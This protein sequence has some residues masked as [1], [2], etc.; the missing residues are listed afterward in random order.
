MSEKQKLALV[1][2]TLAIALVLFFIFLAV[3]DFLN[4]TEANVES[5]VAYHMELIVHAREERVGAAVSSLRSD[6]LLG[7]SSLAC[8]GTSDAAEAERFLTLF[9]S[10]SAFDEL[11]VAYPDGSSAYGGTAAAGE[12]W[13]SDAA[14]GNSGIFAG[15]DGTLTAYAPV[16][17]NGR[18]ALL[19]FGR[20]GAAHLGAGV[21]ERLGEQ[22]V[23]FFLV[24]KSGSFLY[25]PAEQGLFEASDIEAAGGFFAALA[26]AKYP[27]GASAEDIQSGIAQNASGSFRMKTALQDAY[28]YY[29]PAGIADWHVVL[30][31]DYTALSAQHA[32]LGRMAMELLLK[33]LFALLVAALLMLFYSWASKQEALNSANR[34]N[35]MTNAIPGGVQQFEAFGNMEFRYVSDGFFQMTGYS[36]A[37]IK[38]TFSN[39]FLALIHPEDRAQ[40]ESLLRANLDTQTPLELKYRILAKDGRVVWLLNRATLCADAESAAYYQCVCVDITHLKQVEQTLASKAQLDQLT[41]LYNRETA[42]MFIREFLNETAGRNFSHAFFMLDM[43]GFK[44]H[45]DTYGHV[46]GDRLLCRVASI[47]G[48]IFRGTDI[49]CRLAGDEF[50][51]FMKNAE[52]RE[53]IAEKAQGVL[54]GVEELRLGGAA[55]PVSLSIGISLAPEDGASFEELYKR[56]DEALYAAKRSGK[57]R[58]VFFGAMPKL[59]R[60][61]SIFEEML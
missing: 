16:F 37:Q 52:S 22:E 29:A 57:N 13:L 40:V 19:F 12:P 58:Y 17:E 1:L 5:E 44:K 7:A 6:A 26:S 43:D 30:S 10:H 59:E 28:L 23:S 33:V 32:G 38:S 36:E 9:R 60:E 41:G 24:Q 15:D 35:A 31:V 14:L 39:S 11:G 50:V 18:V 46:E 4:R 45:N 56:A 3:R 53:V 27:G 55:L 34:I 47:L 61:K 21:P 54:N 20:Y 25:S 2:N 8:Y 42:R 51:V 48:S 49:L